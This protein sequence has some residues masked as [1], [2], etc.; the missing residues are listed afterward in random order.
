MVD[1]PADNSLSQMSVA[2]PEL[3]PADLNCP[4]VFSE[5]FTESLPIE[6]DLGSG[7]GKFLLCAARQFPDRNFLGVERL[8]GR[9]RK[10]RR[11]AAEA[12]LNNLRIMRLEIGYAVRY[13]FP[14]NSVRRVHLYFPDPWPKRKHHRRRM[15]EPG[16]LRDLGRTIEPGGD[17]LIKTD[18][19]EY[20]R[21]IT[22]AVH[23]VAPCLISVDWIE[24]EYPQTDF[25]EAF[26]RA[27][28][29]IYRLRLCKMT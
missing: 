2:D 4:L 29:P 1:W 25:E 23:S 6:L 20:F 13:L 27:G 15:I 12:G 19:A 17:I 24:Q 10:I 18:H 8:L 7:S 16:F 28:T 5:V 14:P 11:R 3:S 21:Q 22:Q 9:V 26:E